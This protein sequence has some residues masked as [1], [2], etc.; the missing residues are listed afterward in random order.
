MSLA[1]VVVA[2]FMMIVGIGALYLSFRRNAI[3]W[4][5]ISTVIFSVMV[6]QTLTI[7]FSS[8]VTTTNILLSGVCLLFTFIALLKSI[9][10]GFEI[11][12]R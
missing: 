5:I 6:I 1:E 7:P 4:S 3:V 10:L 11:F 2:V 12:K 8:D 9:V